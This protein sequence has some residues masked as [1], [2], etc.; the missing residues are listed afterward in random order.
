MARPL[1]IEYPGA[2]YHITSRGNAKRNIFLNNHDR[3]N[4]L[5]ILNNVV[6]RFNW[7][8]HCYCLM[9]NHYH[10]VIETPDGNL[11]RGMRQLNGV[12]TQKFNYWHNNVGHIFQ[13]RYKSILVDKDNYL[14]EVCRYVVLNPVRAALVN[15]PTEWYWSSYR[16]T[17][18]YE[19]P[20]KFLTVNWILGQ[21]SSKKTVAERDYMKFIKEGIRDNKL[22]K[23]LAGNVVFGNKDFVEKISQFIKPKEKIKEIPRSQ[24]YISRPSIDE[25]FKNKERIDKK[26]LRLLIKKAYYYG[27]TMKQ[28]AERLEIHYATVSRAL[29]KVE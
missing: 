26:S 28:I 13:G 1:R 11:S 10:L 3:N 25:L 23:K 12:Y 20:R 19:K 18:G 27:Y 4:F 17:A 6:E 14:I 5:K 15:D 29:R 9:N 8:V 21:F 22:W 7:L 24:R 2:I 16:A